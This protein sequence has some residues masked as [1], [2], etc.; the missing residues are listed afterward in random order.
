MSQQLPRCYNS[1]TDIDLLRR[2][3]EQINS[4]IMLI[5]HDSGV[6]A[7]MADYVVGMYAGKLLK[8]APLMIYFTTHAIL[9]QL[10]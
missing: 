2:L 5:T 6:I 9:T 10:D 4:S 3:K 8:R 7:E 1:G